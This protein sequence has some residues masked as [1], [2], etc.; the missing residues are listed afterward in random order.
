MDNFDHC[1]QH[2]CA[3]PDRAARTARSGAE[4]SKWVN[5]RGTSRTF[6]GNA[7]R[8]PPAEKKL[9]NS[10]QIFYKFRLER[11]FGNNHNYDIND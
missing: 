9:H 7:V 1:Y 6:F 5:E 8:M 11:V 10:S 3:N 2:I 4:Q